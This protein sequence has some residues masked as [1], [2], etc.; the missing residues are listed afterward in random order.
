MGF[1]RPLGLVHPLG[2]VWEGRLSGE[3][4]VFVFRVQLL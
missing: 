4:V 2:Y 3:G 1:E